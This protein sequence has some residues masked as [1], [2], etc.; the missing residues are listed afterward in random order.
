[1]EQLYLRGS[2]TGQDHVPDTLMG[3]LAERID[4][5]G[6]MKPL[7][8]KVSA[9]GRSFT[10]EMIE[11][12]APE[13]DRPSA[14]LNALVKAGVLD[15]R[16]EVE[17]SF[18]HALLR[19]AA[20]QSILRKT[21]RDLHGTICDLLIHRFPQ[22]TARDPAI[23]A[24]HQSKA[25]RLT[26]SVQSFLAAS[27]WALLQGAFTDAEGHA[28]HALDL[29]Q[30][31]EMAPKRPDL[32]IECYTAIGS[33][34]M[35]YAG[36]TAPPVE[37]AFDQVHQIARTRAL[38][39][40]ESSAALF[41]SFSFAIMA[42]DQRKSDEFQ[43]LLIDLSKRGTDDA[44]GTEVQLAA[45]AAQN[46]SGFYKGN[47]DHQF[48]K[49]AQIRGIYRAEKHAMMITRYGMDI[50]AAAQMFEAP[51]RAITGTTDRVTD[52]VAETDA[53]QAVLNI[54]VMQPYALIWGAVPLWYLGA[55]DAAR[56]R[57][58][59]GLAVAQDQQAEFWQLTGAAWHHV[60]NAPGGAPD[61]AFLKSF[62][63][64]IATHDAVGVNIGA[65]YFRAHFAAQLAAAGRMEEAYAAGSKSVAQSRAHSLHVWYPEILRLHAR[66]CDALGHGDE[67]RTCRTLARETAARQGAALWTLRLLLDQ[68]AAGQLEAEPLAQAVARFDPGTVVPEV[69]EGRALLSRA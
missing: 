58:A 22:V 16:S 42:A 68:A 51:A 12:I 7:L 55:G 27:K 45:L 2:T 14:S 15:R 28:R 52:L 26:E 47:F 20:Y 62:G 4:E 40:Q 11:A 9:I 48:Q 37:E 38:P 44:T 8:Q 35:Q 10:L 43:D 19:D 21:R 67:A 61:P 32:E 66:T 65:P 64:V 29:C 53:H 5:A 33:V 17:W 59:E 23:L 63:Q 36:F 31:P 69:E 25:G 18:S 49:I 30:A 34:V 57:L 54:P 60:M 56:A 13:F 41:G 3:L 6:A 39:G 46:C 1:I 50:F 24:E